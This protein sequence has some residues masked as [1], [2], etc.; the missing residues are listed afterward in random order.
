MYAL[1]LRESKLTFGNSRIGYLWAIISPII[2]ISL[3]VIIFSFA[4]REPPFGQSLALFFSTGFLVFEFYRKLSVSLMRC[5]TSNKGLLVY[6]IVHPISIISARFLLI[7]ITYII[8]FFLFYSALIILGLASYPNNYIE[9]L[10]AFFSITLFGLSIGVFN[11]MMIKIWRSWEY[12]FQILNRPLFFISGIFFIPSLLPEKAIYYLK[13]NPIMHV[14]EWMRVGYYP[15]YYSSILDKNYILC[16]SFILLFLG[17]LGER[18][19]RKM[20]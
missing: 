12:F 2:G 15:N 13:W 9:I 14:I 10:C 18:N 20:Y 6:P 5:L 11:L 19:I 1:L 3:L 7:T 8:I 17:L 16:L 4:S